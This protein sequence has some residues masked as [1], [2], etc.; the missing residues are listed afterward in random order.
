MSE[1]KMKELKQIT[2]EERLSNLIE[3]LWC[4]DDMPYVG[5]KVQMDTTDAQWLIRLAQETITR[6]KNS[7]DYWNRVNL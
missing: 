4:Y 1:L 7:L 3:A 2:D 5:S 6:N